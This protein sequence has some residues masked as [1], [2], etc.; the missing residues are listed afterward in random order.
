M[1]CYITILV[2]FLLMGISEGGGNDFA[3]YNN[4]TIE[5]KVCCDTL[6]AG[7]VTEVTNDTLSMGNVTAKLDAIAWVKLV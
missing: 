7:L 1:N 5:M 3:R 2:I 6:F 4:T